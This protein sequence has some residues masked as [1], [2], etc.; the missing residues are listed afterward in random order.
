MRSRVLDRATADKDKLIRW[1]PERAPLPAD[2]LPSGCALGENAMNEETGI[3]VIG[4]VWIALGTLL[5][6]LVIRRL[7]AQPN[8]PRQHGQSQE[9]IQP[10]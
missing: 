2:E 4:V 1:K 9:P 3:T 5:A 7:F 10:L 8:P 6:I